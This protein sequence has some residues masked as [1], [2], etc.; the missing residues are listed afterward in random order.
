M[1]QT[2]NYKL[3]K[4]LT[5]ENGSATKVKDFR[6]KLNKANSSNM[7]TID[8]VLANKSE[9]STNVSGILLASSWKGTSAPFTQ[10]LAVAGLTAAQ[11]GNI[12]VAHSVTLVQ[13]EAVR[14]AK[15]CVTGQTDGKL[16]ITADGEKPKVD[17]PVVITLLG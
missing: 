6:D 7:T 15:L 8:N 4:E 12:S 1:S 16:S 14:N 17:I 13:R 9:K 10:E 2:L 11:N 5:L 3:I